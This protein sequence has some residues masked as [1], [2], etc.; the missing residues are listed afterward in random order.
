MIPI[1]ELPKTPAP[2]EDQSTLET[3]IAST[4]RTDETKEEEQDSEAKAIQR[5]LEKDKE[6]GSK[7]TLVEDLEDLDM[8]DDFENNMK[9]LEDKGND[10]DKGESRN[11]FTDKSD[12]NGSEN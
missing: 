7:Q 5:V 6:G 11:S 1:K 12:E 4:H 9:A 8:E 2:A 10:D 3:T